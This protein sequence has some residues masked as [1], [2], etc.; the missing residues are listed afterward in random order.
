MK[1]SVFRSDLQEDE[2]VFAAEVP[3]HL[4]KRFPIYAFV[5]D[6]ESTPCRL[7]AEDLEQERRNA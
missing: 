4:G 1:T 5:V 3:R 6:A 7:V 2:I